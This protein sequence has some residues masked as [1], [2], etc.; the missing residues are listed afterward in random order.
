MLFSKNLLQAIDSL[1]TLLS[2]AASI[3]RGILENLLERA[4]Q[5]KIQQDLEDNPP[6]PVWQDIYFLT[7]IHIGILFGGYTAYLWETQ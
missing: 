1:E 6:Q 5:K 7:I 2:G 4:N 3:R